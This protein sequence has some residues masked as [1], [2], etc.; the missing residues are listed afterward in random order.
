[1]ENN[2]S[3]PNNHFQLHVNIHGKTLK[4]TETLFLLIMV[5]EWKN[6]MPNQPP[7]SIVMEP[8]ALRTL[9]LTGLPKILADSE[10]LKM[11]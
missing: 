2:A 3:Q 5:H 7:A 4:T 6:K 9:P 11:L 8:L 1:M 10:N